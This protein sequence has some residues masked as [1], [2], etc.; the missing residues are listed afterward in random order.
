[1]AA[2]LVASQAATK[3]RL[4]QQSRLQLALEEALGSLEAEGLLASQAATC[5]RRVAGEALRRDAGRWPE[6]RLGGRLVGYRA[7]RGEWTMHLDK[8]NVQVVPERRSPASRGVCG[9]SRQIRRLKV[10]GSEVVI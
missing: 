4:A 2:P 1:M 10:I 8:V 5:I 7:L 9:A 3:G 6:L